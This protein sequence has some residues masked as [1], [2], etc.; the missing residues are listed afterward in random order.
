MK[1]ND[2]M[3]INLQLFAEDPKKPEED[4]S[5]LETEDEEL[6]IDDDDESED[7]DGLEDSEG[8]KKLDIKEPDKQP[9]KKPDDG[10]R[11][12]N[13]VIA[14]RKRWQKKLEALKNQTPSKIDDDADGE[15]ILR[16]AGINDDVI[17]AFMKLANKSGSKAEGTVSKVSKKLRDIEFRELKKDYADIDDYR[18]ELEELSEKSGFSIEETYLARY[19]KQKFSAN[20]ADLEREIETRIRD[21][22]KKK[23][24]MKFDATDNGETDTKKGKLTQEQREAAKFLGMSEREYLVFSK[25]KSLDQMDKYLKK[26]G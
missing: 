15:K 11:V 4:L 6:T 21:E 23:G 10:E 2:W 8:D 16:D 9:D 14:E 1:K 17:K 19:G 22:I 7:I 12:R 20:K 24:A 5:D 25:A 18:D 13:A 26:K 3:K